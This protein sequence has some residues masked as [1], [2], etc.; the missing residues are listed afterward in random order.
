MSTIRSLFSSADS[1]CTNSNRT[2]SVISASDVEAR[3]AGGP[4]ASGT[5]AAA[6][7]SASRRGIC[8]ARLELQKKSRHAN[9]ILNTGKVFIS[10]DERTERTP[11]RRTHTDET[12]LRDTQKAP[13]DAKGQVKHK[14][15]TPRKHHTRFILIFIARSYMFVS[16][17]L[18]LCETAVSRSLRFPR[19]AEGTSNSEL[20]A[21]EKVV[22][23]RFGGLRICMFPP[24]PNRATVENG[25]LSGKEP[26]PQKPPCRCPQ[27]RKAACGQN[28]AVSRSAHT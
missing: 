4:I 28:R 11:D 9:F 10:P 21:V 8:S 1:C 13:H 2:R 23:L 5:R 18:S 24:P 26:I 3:A 20:T 12:S 19:E 17:R 14:T 25:P 27:N 6:A 16:G 7:R 15:F 22:S